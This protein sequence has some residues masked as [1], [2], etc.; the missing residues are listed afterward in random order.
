VEENQNQNQN[1][2]P[3]KPK[4]FVARHSR[5][6]SFIAFVAGFIWD[7]LTLTYVNLS[8]AAVILGAYLAVIAVGIIVFQGI[9]SR[10]EQGWRRKIAGGIPYVIQFMFGTL[11]NA[12]L[13][14]YTRSA[15]L[16]ASWP[17]LLFLAA[18]IFGNE[19]FRKRQAR[20]TFQIA[21]FFIAEFLYFVFAVPIVV[22]KIGAGIFI[23]SG[24]VSLLVLGIITLVVSKVA[25]GR[26]L[27]KRT[28]R[29]FIIGAVYAALNYSYFANLIPPIPLALKDA[30]VF[31]SVTKVSGEYVVKY[32]PSA[33]YV[34]WRKESDVFHEVPGETAYVWS[35]VFAPT[36][37]SLPVYHEWEH[38]DE[39]KGEW[40]L[41]SRI[42]F[43]IF[44][45]RDGGYRGYTFKKDPLPGKW[46]V[47]ITTETGGRLGRVS[48][49][50][51]LA[52]SSPLLETG[53]R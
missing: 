31:H 11:F 40:I 4:N 51:V 25:R 26:F 34:F 24:L 22:G 12:S 1:P 27:E 5:L 33:P 37:F 9:S 15:E 49:T 36:A 20:L 2:S 23:L 3:E 28:I 35:A 50:V 8:E 44:G 32:E 38:F 41:S 16:S 13:I 30:G 53:L 47:D 14:F 6:V 10:Y 39:Q 19:L 45:G 18:V 42:Q 48:F 17:F 46:R 29:I 21:L 52:S 43:Q 7:G